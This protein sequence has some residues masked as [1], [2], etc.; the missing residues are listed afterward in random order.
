MFLDYRA[1]VL[2]SLTNLQVL[3]GLDRSG[4]PTPSDDILADIPGNYFAVLSI[5]FK[6]IPST[7][8]ENSLGEFLNPNCSS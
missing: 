8:R 5:I 3:D 6:P 7:K 2:N 1:L 4:K